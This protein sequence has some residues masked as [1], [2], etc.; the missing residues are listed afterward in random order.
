MAHAL[1]VRSPLLDHRVVEFA[2]RLPL[3]FKISGRTTKRI[4]K[5]VARRHIPQAIV[6]R[7]K[8]G[9]QV[10]LGLWFKTDL[11]E[12]ARE[13]LTDTSHGLFDRK[14]VERIWEEHQTGRADNAHKIWLLLFFNEWWEQFREFIQTSRV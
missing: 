8:Y 12:W 2:C 1:E 13:R 4:L 5:D 3:N 6:D 14:V 7:P 10:P 9:F 11:R